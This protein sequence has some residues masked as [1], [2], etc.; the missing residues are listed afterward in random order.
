MNTMIQVLNYVSGRVQRPG[1]EGT[2]NGFVMV[3]TT[4]WTFE[5]QIQ[6]DQFELLLGMLALRY[7]VVTVVPGEERYYPSEYAK[8]YPVI[9]V[10]AVDTMGGKFPWSPGRDEVTVTAPG[11]VICALDNGGQ[12]DPISIMSATA[13]AGGLAAYFLSLFPQLRAQEQTSLRVKNWM[14][15][16]SW[17]RLPGGLPSIWN[18][19]EPYTPDASGDEILPNVPY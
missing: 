17:A 3:F 18:L 9:S 7:G 16:N 12:G 11:A 14:V 5:G 19:M 4:S 10:G 15:S 6:K 13:Q 8:T 2:G 1:P